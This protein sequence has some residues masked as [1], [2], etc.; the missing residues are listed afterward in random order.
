MKEVKPILEELQKGS[1][2]A[3]E[4][5]EQLRQLRKEGRSGFWP[6]LLGGLP[7]IVIGSG[8]SHTVEEELTIEYTGHELELDLASKNGSL[9]LQGWDSPEIKIQLCKKIRH[10]SQED[11]KELAKTTGT[12]R[13]EG[14]KLILAAD[15][16]RVSVSA[17]VFIPLQ[18]VIRGQLKTANG[19]I[20]L[21][22]LTGESLKLST[23]NG[24]LALDKVNAKQALLKS[25]NGRI[26]VLGSLQELEAKTT[27][28]SIAV[29]NTAPKQCSRLVTVNGSVKVQTPV[30]EDTA[31]RLQANTTSGSIRVDLP[32]GNQQNYYRFSGRRSVDLSRGDFTTASHQVQLELKTVNGS[33]N[34]SRAD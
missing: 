7:D 31:V 29:T 17:T 33:I 15:D 9:R 1:I 6:G 14:N 34:I 26:E 19:S 5:E 8:P 16:E 23:A 13:L 24:S 32:E 30:Q 11:A 25:V 18:L 27:N 28:G 22:A 3:V 20:A 10:S 2:T 21:L 4:A 12:P